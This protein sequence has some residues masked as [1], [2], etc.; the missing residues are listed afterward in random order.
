M[1]QLCSIEAASYNVMNS[2]FL[3]QLC[4]WVM[5]NDV[6]HFSDL[7]DFKVIQV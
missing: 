4:Y 2:S 6:F 3:E 7:K 5:Y 1:L